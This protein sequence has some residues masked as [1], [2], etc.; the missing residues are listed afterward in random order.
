MV[1][2]AP[3]GVR[4]WAVSKWGAYFPGTGPAAAQPLPNFPV[5]R[6]QGPGLHRVR[7]RGRG[8]DLCPNGGGSSLRGEEETTF[9]WSSHYRNQGFVKSL[10]IS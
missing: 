8:Y 4:G 7:G 2:S 6:L 5:Y 9:R 3:D 1:C 10:L